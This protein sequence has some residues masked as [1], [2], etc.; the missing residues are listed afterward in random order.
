[1]PFDQ[2]D[3]IVRV[4][5]GFR[6][7]PFE[8][9]DLVGVDVN[10]SV[11]ISFWEQSFHEPRWRP[12]PLQTRLID[13]GRLGRKSGRGWYR[14]ADG[15]HRP[16]D[17][18]GPLVELP[19]DPSFDA[20]AA[21]AAQDGRHV[22]RVPI[23]TP[24]LVLGRILAQLVNEAYFALGEGVASADDI[25]T[26]MRLGFNWPKGPFEWA[27]EIGPA[28]VEFTLG[29]LQDTLGEDRYRIAPALRAAAAAA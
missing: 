2:I 1:V 4:G 14:Y 27:D 17:P 11:A 9:M 15:P 18:E 10:T 21:S 16:D 26:A 19:T 8:L 6:M 28:E 13:S 20:E 23:D 25:N 22:E 29:A 5:G 3:R 7:G 12:S 24:G